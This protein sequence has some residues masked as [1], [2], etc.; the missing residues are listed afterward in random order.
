M[1]VL[2]LYNLRIRGSTREVVIASTQQRLRNDESE[3]IAHLKKYG[4]RNKEI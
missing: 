1:I 4:Q 3:R 2:D